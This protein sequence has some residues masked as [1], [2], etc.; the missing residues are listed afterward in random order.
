MRRFWFELSCDYSY[1]VEVNSAKNEDRVK[2]GHNASADFQL[3]TLMKKHQTYTFFFFFAHAFT[4]QGKK[5]EENT[6]AWHEAAIL[7][8]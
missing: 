1:L 8:T 5:K 2:E 6:S 3:K 7:T 4:R